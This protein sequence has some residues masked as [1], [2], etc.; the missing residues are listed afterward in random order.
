MSIPYGYEMDMSHHS[1]L[2]TTDNHHLQ[3]RPNYSNKVA[4]I[5]GSSTGIGFETALLL[6]RSGFHT[7]ASM[8]DLK[9]SNNI[10]EIA[11]TENLP[12]TVVQLDVKDDSSV[13]DAIGKIIAESKRID[14]LVN[15][16][17]YGLFSP[18]EDVTLDQ[19]KEQFETNFFGAI[20]VMHEVIPTM[21]K[22]RDGTIVN[23]S[24]LVGRI[25]LPLSSAY[26]ATKF[27]LEGLSESM[28]YEL[29]EFGINIILI[30]PG[31]IKTNFIENLKTADTTL[32]SESPYADLVDR[33]SKKF[34]KMMNNISSPKLVAEA[35]LHA[36]TSKEPKIRYVV[37]DDVNSMMK[38]R[39]NSTD[40][41]FENW[42]YENV[43][44]KQQYIFARE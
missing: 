41:E 27:A 22:Q 15:N 4:V 1:R 34:G 7:Y 36:I 12:L 26:V 3:Y 31:V 2:T 25:G 44:Q 42:V 38:I 39:E 29:N 32:K 8:R 24:S 16:A 21:R 11:K 23:I 30:E 18:L 13:K 35:I 20:R 40:K 19:V 6:A 37:G 5:T 10:A 33:I 17:G 9:K 28:R 43:L 14:V